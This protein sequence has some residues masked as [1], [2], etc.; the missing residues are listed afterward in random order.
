MSTAVLK[1][2]GASSDGGQ[3]STPK[4]SPNL[5]TSLSGFATIM[6]AFGG[7]PIFPSIQADMTNRSNFKYSSMISHC[8]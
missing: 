8:S 3:T 5:L 1:V 4:F 2:C 6:F 7:A